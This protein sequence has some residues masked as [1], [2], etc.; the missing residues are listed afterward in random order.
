M[1]HLSAIHGTQKRTHSCVFLVYLLP[2][3]HSGA[4]LVRSGGPTPASVAGIYAAR[5]RA[6]VRYLHG[7]EGRG[8]PIQKRSATCLYVSSSGASLCALYVVWPFWLQYRL[9]STAA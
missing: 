5:D 1:M 8:H 2:G 6:L 7:A 4:L 9:I 3:A